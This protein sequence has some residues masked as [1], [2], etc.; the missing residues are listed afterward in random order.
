MFRS[1]WCLAGNGREHGNHEIWDFVRTLPGF[2]FRMV[3]RE[4]GDR[5]EALL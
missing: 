1:F 3:G 4:W 5:V 2:V